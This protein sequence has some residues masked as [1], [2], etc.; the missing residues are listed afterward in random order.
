MPSHDVMPNM[1]LFQPT[2]VED[3]LSLAD[4]FAERGWLVGERFAPFP[5]KK[6]FGFFIFFESLDL[7][8]RIN[9]FTI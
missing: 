5:P 3:A 2:Q 6:F 8:F 9:L 1:E 7:K 4:R